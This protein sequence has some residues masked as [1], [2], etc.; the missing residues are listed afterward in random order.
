MFHLRQWLSCV[1][2]LI[3]LLI[4]DN[5]NYDIV[6]HKNVSFLITTNHTKNVDKDINSSQRETLNRAHVEIYLLC[7]YVHDYEKNNIPR[8]TKKLK[9]EVVG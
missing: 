6:E 2:P 4:A 3:V 5:V 9:I 1:S 7:F 8:S